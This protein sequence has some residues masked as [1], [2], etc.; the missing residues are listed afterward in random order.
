MA[1]ESTGRLSLRPIRPAIQRV[2]VYETRTKMYIVGSTND[3]NS[4]RMLKI[5]RL[6]SPSLGLEIEEDEKE[7]QEHEAKVTLKM[8]EGANQNSTTKY[9][10]GLQQVAS[11]FGIVGFIRFLEGY[12]VI[13]ITKRK[14]VATIG[15]HV[16]YK[17]EDTLVYPIS[18]S[19][20]RPTN[21]D[22]SR[23]LK[24][25][26]NVDLSSNFYFSYSYDLTHSLQ[27]QMRTSSGPAPPSCTKFI[28][29]EHMLKHFEGHVHS[30]W[31]LHVICGFV[32]QIS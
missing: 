27:C 18:S 14:P 11:A 6:T 22:E 13:L 29:N 9:Q 7:Y 16:L 15:G 24:I 32:S 31:V 26:Q 8:L 5:D 20:G 12:Y 25:F 21:A 19:A 17:I 23:Y 1:A 30:R 3:G 4:C 10:S 2:A 28:W